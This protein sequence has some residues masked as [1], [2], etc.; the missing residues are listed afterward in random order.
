M[1]QHL[2]AD[3]RVDAALSLQRHVTGIGHP[4]RDRRT[5]LVIGGAASDAGEALPRN[6]DLQIDTIEQR[7]GQTRT[8]RPD[9]VPAAGTA[10]VRITQLAAGAWIHR[11]DELEPRRESKLVSGPRDADFTCLDGLAEDLQC[12]TAELGQLVKKQDAVVCA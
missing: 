9:P 5:R 12:V 10:A 3:A 4:R 6:L 1:L 2:P 11:R 7:T 8:V